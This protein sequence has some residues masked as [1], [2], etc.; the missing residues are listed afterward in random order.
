M[1]FCQYMWCHIP[2]WSNN[3]PE[4]I[5]SVLGGKGFL[6]KNKPNKCVGI[7]L[8]AWADLTWALRF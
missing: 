6:S 8:L 7:M 5:L 3:A 4:S 1:Q 2:F